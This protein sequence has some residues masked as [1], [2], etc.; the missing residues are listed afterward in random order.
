MKTITMNQATVL[1]YVHENHNHGLSFQDGRVVSSLFKKGYIVNVDWVATVTDAGY[2]ALAQYAED[3]ARR[4]QK[5]IAE[6]VEMGIREGDSAND[7]Q[8]VSSLNLAAKWRGM[9]GE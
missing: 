6:W 4:W 2:E 1:E 3:N 5:Q 7:F 8:V 9:K